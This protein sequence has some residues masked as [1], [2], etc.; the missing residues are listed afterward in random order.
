MICGTLLGVTFRYREH[1]VVY[2]RLTIQTGWRTL[3][4]Q[5]PRRTAR[6]PE[7]TRRP[8]SAG[9]GVLKEKGEENCSWEIFIG[10]PV[11]LHL[12]SRSAEDGLGLRAG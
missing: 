3:F 10:V 5:K 11:P 6:V 12:F 9:G 2:Y 1:Q 7:Q 4:T 8:T